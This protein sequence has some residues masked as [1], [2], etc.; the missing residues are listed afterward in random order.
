MRDD[1]DLAG[2][3]KAKSAFMKARM[4][5]TFA[6]TVCASPERRVLSSARS[7]CSPW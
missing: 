2:P 1:V 7:H 4:S 6:A 3:V 5:G